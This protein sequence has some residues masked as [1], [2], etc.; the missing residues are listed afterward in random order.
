MFSVYIHWPIPPFYVVDEYVMIRHTLLTVH[1]R[2]VVVE[3]LVNETQSSSYFVS[4]MSWVHSNHLYI[5]GPSMLSTCFYAHCSVCVSVC[6]V[7]C[8]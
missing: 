4:R 5:H 8:V 2:S 1:L 3:H 6:C 7:V